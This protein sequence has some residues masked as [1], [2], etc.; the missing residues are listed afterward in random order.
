M[1]SLII[2]VI[3]IFVCINNRYVTFAVIYSRQSQQTPI[4]LI[5]SFCLSV[6]EKYK[7]IY[8]CQVYVY[9][10]L[11]HSCIHTYAH[12][13]MHTQTHACMYMCAHTHT[14]TQTH[15]HTHFI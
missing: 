6:P 11:S 3:A 13:Y 4:P 7:R 5:Q 12:T 14:H 10:Y 1:Y 8:N 9:M 15:T 2:P